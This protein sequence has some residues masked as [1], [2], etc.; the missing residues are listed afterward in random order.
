VSR[1][2]KKLFTSSLAVG[3]PGYFGHLEHRTETTAF[4]KADRTALLI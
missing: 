1:E 3:L 4:R 2:E